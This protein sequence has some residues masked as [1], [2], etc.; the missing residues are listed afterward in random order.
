MTETQQLLRV[1]V[2]GHR[3]LAEIDKLSASLVKVYRILAAHYP[4]RPI[5][6]ASGLAEGADCLTAQVFLAQ[7]A[8]LTAVLPLRQEE[9]LQDFSNA[10]SKEAFET[11]LHRAGKIISLP[12]QP[13]H[14]QAYR[15]LGDYLLQHSDLLITLWDGK[16]SSS[17]GSTGDISL[18]AR[19]AGLPLIWVH[20]GNR[21][22]NTNLPTSLGNK[23]GKIEFINF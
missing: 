18:R 8:F 16:H 6:L 14:P 1:G 19:A 10:E 21:I 13:D 17:P 22:P 20:A 11:L 9:Y 7:G 5:E 3:F 15:A 23:Q 2:T 4:D 12:A